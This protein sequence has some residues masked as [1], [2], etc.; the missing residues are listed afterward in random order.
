MAIALCRIDERLLHGQVLVGWGG[1]LAISRYLVVDDDLAASDWEQDLYASGAPAGCETLFLSVAEGIRQ[2]EE[3]DERPGTAALITRDTDAMRRL[4]DAGLLDGRR[5]NIGGLHE[6]RERR[7]VLDYVYLGPR[8]IED[9]QAIAGHA[10]QVAAR[11]LPNSAAVPL[12]E[13]IDA[14]ERA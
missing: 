10:G 5:V 12:S 13:L 3:I 9:L 7:R 8:E 2:F 1:L 11:D 6:G 14:A 4:A